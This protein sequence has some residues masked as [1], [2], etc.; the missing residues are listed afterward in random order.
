MLSNPRKES[1]PSFSF[2]WILIE[3]EKSKNSRGPSPKTRTGYGWKTIH[4]LMEVSR[5]RLVRANEACIKDLFSLEG[6][7]EWGTKNPIWIYRFSADSSQLPKQYPWCSS[8]EKEIKNAGTFVVTFHAAGCFHFSII[9]S[10][11]HWPSKPMTKSASTVVYFSIFHTAVAASQQY[12]HGT[13]KL[14]QSKSNPGFTTICTC[15]K[16]G[17]ML[18]SYC[19]ATTM[20]AELPALIK[21][22]CALKS[23]SHIDRKVKA[24]EVPGRLLHFSKSL[25]IVWTHISR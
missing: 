25:L 15:Q 21:V 2:F 17:Q 12:P 24:K 7:A 3:F 16:M 6:T 4:L 1:N 5:D 18:R 23:K 14:L 13:L 20:L 10:V 9:Q 11:A 22:H 19:T 8:N